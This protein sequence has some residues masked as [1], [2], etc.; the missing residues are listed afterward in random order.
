M[1]KSCD[2][3]C[4]QP[5]TDELCPV[6]RGTGAIVASCVNCSG[7]GRLPAFDPAAFE[8]AKDCANAS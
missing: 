4:D 5:V 8:I 3:I 1:A 6:C 2:Q 7:T